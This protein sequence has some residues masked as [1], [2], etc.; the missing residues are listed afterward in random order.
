VTTPRRK[1]WQYLD[2]PFLLPICFQMHAAKMEELGDLGWEAYAVSRTLLL[3]HC[4]HLKRPLHS[5]KSGDES[6]D[7]RDD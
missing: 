4:I 3:W 1:Q 6:R 7:E 2:Y 5:E